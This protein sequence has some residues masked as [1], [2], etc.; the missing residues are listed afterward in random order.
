MSETGL[1]IAAGETCHGCQKPILPWQSSTTMYRKSEPPV[2][3]HLDCWKPTP[4][5]IF[6]VP[7]E[8]EALAWA[9]QAYVY[10]SFGAIDYW[11]LCGCSNCHRDL[12]ENDALSITLDLLV[13]EH[14]RPSPTATAGSTTP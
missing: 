3:H 14:H 9:R 8:P 5:P 1:S 2:T 10:G 13:A 12:L 4:Q 11:D 7:G 6:V